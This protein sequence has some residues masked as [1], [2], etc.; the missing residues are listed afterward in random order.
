M[1]EKLHL[2]TVLFVYVKAKKCSVK[3][4]FTAVHHHVLAWDYWYLYYLYNNHLNLPVFTI[5][6]TQQNALNYTK[7]LMKT[8]TSPNQ[9]VLTRTEFHTQLQ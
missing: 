1:L 8:I 3:D 7:V 4:C 6:T 2:I 9:Y 5:I